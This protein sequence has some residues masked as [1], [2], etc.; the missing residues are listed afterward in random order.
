MSTE[1]LRALL[2]IAFGAL[3]GGLTNTI[4]IWMLFHP[5]EPPRIGRWRLSFLQGAVPKN[6]ARLASAIGR[7]VGG[8]LLT[9]EDLT[10]IFAD[11]EFRSAFDARLGRFLTALLDRERG[12]LRELIPDASLPT[13]EK[14]LEEMA[15]QAVGRA[16]SYLD[17]D[18]FQ[19]AIGR[20]A[21]ELLETVA[22]ERVGNLLTAAREAALTR[23]VDEWLSGAV[24]SDGFRRAVDDYLERGAVQLLEPDRTFEEI[25][26]VGLV[27]S[28]ERA[29]SGYLPLAIARFGALLE[30]PSARARFETT[31]NELLHGFLSDLRFHQRVV[32]R[33]IV[34]EETVDRVLRTVEAEG[35]E[36]V[37]EMLRDP[38]VQ[39][40]MARGV[41]DAIVEFLRRPVT[42]VLGKPGDPNVVEAQKTMSGW[43]VGMARDPATREFLVEKLDVALQKAGER[44]W[45]EIFERVPPE[46]IAG[47]VVSA[48]RSDTARKVLGDVLRRGVRELLDRPIGRPSDWLPPDTPKRLE[49]ALSDPIWAWLQTQVPEVVQHM[50]VAR[51]VEEKVLE[52][53]APKMEELVRR[54]T[55]RELRL[56]VKLGYLLGAIIGSGLVGINYLLG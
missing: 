55:D 49:S 46:K 29:I 35:A 19:E 25:L 40:A 6:Q 45:G 47:L 14:I 36:R 23:A 18:A 44:T 32:A 20:R 33:L 16:E 3:A 21:G 37:S 4:A 43:A 12:S 1:L 7:T 24:E 15:E 22:D 53:P 31:M 41:N 9:G 26:P 38:S 42:S 27:T 52:Y 5:F 28:L 48:A 17:S 54:V 2:T 8:K 34:N 30:D 11:E 39:E 56:I 10:R 13:V 50:D 51:R